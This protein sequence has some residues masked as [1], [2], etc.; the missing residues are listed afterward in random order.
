MEGEQEAG[1]AARGMPSLWQR[2]GVQ[3]RGRRALLWLVRL[4][5]L[6][7]R[8]P[9]VANGYATARLA[10]IVAARRGVSRPW[11]P[12]SPTPTYQWVSDDAEQA[13]G[14][15]GV[16]IAPSEQAS[17]PLGDARHVCGVHSDLCGGGL[18]REL[19]APQ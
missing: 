9:G 1:A 17:R 4:A 10:P 16:K 8:R 18:C 7:R 19:R 2:D 14:G 12:T 6:L 3:V 5:R 15:T 13:D 11:V